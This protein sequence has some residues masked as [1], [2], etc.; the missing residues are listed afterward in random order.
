MILGAILG[1]MSH[2]ISTTC[3]VERSKLSNV[4][5][6]KA[7][8]EYF[9]FSFILIYLTI[10][11]TV[12]REILDLERESELVFRHY[13]LRLSFCHSICSFR[14]N[15]LLLLIKKDVAIICTV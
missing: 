14:G 13:T 5:N 4:V 15:L 12:E 1:I 10:K 7:F 9:F 6:K 2:P 8:V 11:S 3:S